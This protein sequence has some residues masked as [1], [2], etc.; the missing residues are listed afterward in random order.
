MS[1]IEVQAYRLLQKAGIARPRVNLNKILRHLGIRRVLRQMPAH[2]SGALLV[3]EK[4]GPV[5][6][7]NSDHPVTRRRFTTAHEIGHYVLHSDKGLHVDKRADVFLRP[8]RSGSGGDP[9]EREANQF[10]AALL[11]PRPFLRRDYELFDEDQFVVAELA[12]RYRVSPSAMTYR[13][14]NLSLPVIE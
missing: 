7:V 10:A 14:M 3:D 4:V 5:I 1:R 11:M 9:A 8:T 6:G 13:L 12:S 2:L